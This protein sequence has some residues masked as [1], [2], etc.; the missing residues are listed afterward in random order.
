LKLMNEGWLVQVD[1]SNLLQ[2]DINNG[3]VAQIL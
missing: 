3:R 1:G 2:G